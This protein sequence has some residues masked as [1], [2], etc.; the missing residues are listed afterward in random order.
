MCAIWFVLP[1][2]YVHSDNPLEKGKAEWKDG[3]KSK[4]DEMSYKEAKGTL[5]PH[6]VRHPAYDD[7]V[8]LHL[9]DPDVEVRPR[10]HRSAS[11][12][13]QA[14]E[15]PLEM[16]RPLTQEEEDD[17]IWRAKYAATTPARPNPHSIR[18]RRQQYMDNFKTSED[19]NDDAEAQEVKYRS[20]MDEINRG[21]ESYLMDQDDDDISSL[22]QESD[23][24]SELTPNTQQPYQQ[25]PQR[26]ANQPQ[27]QQQQGHA[28]EMTTPESNSTAD[29]HPYSRSNLTAAGQRQRNPRTTVTAAKDKDTRPDYQQHVAERRAKK[30]QQKAQQQQT[31]G[32]NDEDEDD[33]DTVRAREAFLASRKSL[34]SASGQSVVEQQQQ[35]QVSGSVSVTWEDDVKRQQAVTIATTSSASSTSTPTRLGHQQT[36]PPAQQSSKPAA[37]T[38]DSNIYLK[39]SLQPSVSPKSGARLSPLN[40]V[41]VE[42]GSVTS[43]SSSTLTPTSLQSQ[44]PVY[45]PSGASSVASNGQ[46]T[47]LKRTASAKKLQHQPLP[48]PAPAQTTTPVHVVTLATDLV[49]PPAAVTPLSDEISPKSL[50]RTPSTSGMQST[51]AAHARSSNNLLSSKTNHQNSDSYTRNLYQ[52][53]SDDARHRLRSISNS[54]TVTSTGAVPIGSSQDALDHHLGAH[55]EVPGHEHEY[56]GDKEETEEEEEVAVVVD[57]EYAFVNG[58]KDGDAADKV[59]LVVLRGEIVRALFEED[60]ERVLDL[61]GETLLSDFFQVESN[62]A[63]R[64]LVLRMYWQ[65]VHVQR[66]QT[67]LFLVDEGVVSIDAVDASSGKTALQCGVEE[68]AEAYGRELLRRGANILLFDR[69]ENCALSSAL[70]KQCDWL[71][72]EFAM[73]G[74][75]ETLL[76]RGTVQEKYQYLSAFVLAGLA[77]KA[78]ALLATQ[79][80]SITASEATALMN[81]CRGNF[82]RM[83]DPVET[84]ELLMSLGADFVDA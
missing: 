64:D 71:L 39:Q 27:L 9:F 12:M 43:Q 16:R 11:Y 28:P 15:S 40:V 61:L 52:P 75:E 30:A 57:D 22:G 68:N 45:T 24:F 82:Q 84:F 55:I 7:C 34:K 46:Q 56:V 80:V 2:W 37:I 76:Q 69:E 79:L 81:A 6:F 35:Q 62:A 21:E 73:S 50:K 26:N 78:K 59:D 42:E 41:P 77:E 49:F 18:D 74:E 5:A 14:I 3:F 65:C 13:Q 4:L 33:Y 51:S 53:G 1:H 44:P 63:D 58:E 60:T 10:F 20:L 23:A 38:I 8:L 32:S 54:A 31:R 48:S 25:P 29:H 66:Y 19:D 36:Q 47:S 17:L 70:Q 67:A 83:K 72:E